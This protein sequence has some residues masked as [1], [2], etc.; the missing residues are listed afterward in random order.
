MAKSEKIIKKIDIALDGNSSSD[1]TYDIGGSIYNLDEASSDTNS[2]GV[3]E[4]FLIF[5]CGDATENTGMTPAESAS[6]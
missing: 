5:D 3:V 2:Q 4:Y 1:T 6:F